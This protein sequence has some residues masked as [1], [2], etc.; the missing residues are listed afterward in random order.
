MVMQSKSSSLIF[1]P[2]TVEE[3]HGLLK[4]LDQKKA[5]WPDGISA[6]FV[7]RCS[8]MLANSVTTIS[9]QQSSGLEE[10]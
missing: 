1:E 8:G 7:K 6:S 4:T 9:I 3:V 5:M 10:C 2:V